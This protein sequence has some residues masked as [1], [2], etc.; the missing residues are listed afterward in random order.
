MNFMA[1][2]SHRLGGLSGIYIMGFIIVATNSVL[3]YL[4]YKKFFSERISVIG[5]SFFCLFPAVTVQSYLTHSLQ[6][7]TSLMYLLIAILCYLAGKH[8]LSYIII[9][10]TLVSYELTILVFFAVPLLKN[11]WNRKL[12]K[13]TAWH[14]FIL[15][16]LVLLAVLIRRSFGEDR[17]SKIGGGILHKF[18]ESI[19]IGPMTSITQFVNAPLNSI[20]YW[21]L[22]IMSA[23]LVSLAIFMIMFCRTDD[24]D[25]YKDKSL[26]SI[27]NY[28][29]F[30]IS[31]RI[32]ISNRTLMIVINSS[33]MIAIAYIL[34]FTR[35]ATP[36]KIMEWGEFRSGG[37]I[38]VVVGLAFFTGM[39][40]RLNN[41]YLN[42]DNHS[43]LT[44]Q[45]LEFNMF[46]LNLSVNLRLLKLICVSLL[47]L[48]LAYI[49]PFTHYPPVQISGRRTSAHLAAI[50]GG[51]LLFACL[52]EALMSLAGRYRFKK[53][54]IGGLA[55][56]MS[57]LIGYRFVIQEDYKLNWHYQRLLWTDI[58]KNCPD[59]NEGTIILL[60]VDDIPNTQFHKTMTWT[61]YV[62]M[63]RLYKYPDEWKTKPV[64][65]EVKKNWMEKAR[66]KKDRIQII[67]SGYANRERIFLPDSNVILLKFIAGKVKR[68][69]GFVSIKDRKLLLKEKKNGPVPEWEKTVLYE[70]LIDDGTKI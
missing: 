6:L 17:V 26:T 21:D 45:T 65:Y 49:M 42:M 46:G 30:V 33:I 61:G 39:L 41:K 52:C 15:S 59:I 64:L 38:Y 57:L 4:I 70:Y 43:A 1:L 24:N 40:F 27:N 66:I 55:F 54:A 8:I 35:L 19:V 9:A 18:L 29:E 14:S 53:L 12:V 25:T 11:N 13:E 34:S 22:G 2:Y 44:G 3:A 23:S 5:A 69:D 56:Y 20:K 68:I 50:F 60:E 58:I 31:D 62:V 32:K 51:S 67:V 7:Q 37:Y 36:E 28:K 47:M 16:L 10:C 63:V 48:V